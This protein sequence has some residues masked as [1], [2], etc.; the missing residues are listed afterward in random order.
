MVSVCYNI[1]ICTVYLCW[2]QQSTGSNS[3]D[4]LW[5]LIRW[6]TYWNWKQYFASYSIFTY[7]YIYMMEYTNLK[8]SVKF[9]YMF[10]KLLDDLS[11][12][13]I[14]VSIVT[15]FI[16]FQPHII[17]NFHAKSQN[18]TFVNTEPQLCYSLV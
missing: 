12:I 17:L 13:F 3:S 15:L 4:D 9:I 1:R 8:M 6:K 16:R 5:A 2:F 11:Y 18:V 7:Q 14:R 10:I